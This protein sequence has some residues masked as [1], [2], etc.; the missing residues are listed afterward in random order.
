[1]WQPKTMFGVGILSIALLPT[2]ENGV[3]IAYGVMGVKACLT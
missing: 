1:M 2:S 3:T